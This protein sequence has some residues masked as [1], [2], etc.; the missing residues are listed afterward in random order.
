MRPTIN[1]NESVTDEVKRR[2]GAFEKKA[3]QVVASALNRAMT[4]VATNI[5]KETRK[6]YHIKATD[7]KKTISKTRATRANIDA[8][9]VSRGNLIP[10]DRFKVSPR[11]VS[12]NRK[13][14]IKAAVKKTGAKKLKGAFVADVHGIKVFK[15]QT[16]RRLPIDRLFG[17][18]VPQMLDNEVNRRQINIEG[19]NTF[20]RRLDHEIDRILSRGLQE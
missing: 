6:S 17:P 19:R 13:T 4:N 7:I 3:P 11:K 8:I 15:R 18:S 12:P 10:L 16:D 2:L 9:V 1:V 5:S 20:Y 14:P